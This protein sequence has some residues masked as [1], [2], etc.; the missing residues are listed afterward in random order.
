MPKTVFCRPTPTMTSVPWTETAAPMMPKMSAWLD[1]VGS[2][3]TNVMRSH[4]IAATSAAT[5]RSCV[6]TFES[7]MPAPT[8]F[9]TASPESAPTRFRPPAMR[10][11]C[12]GVSTRVATTVAIAFAASWKPLTNSK[13]T[14][15]RTTRISR[16]VALS[17][18][19]SSAVLHD[20]RFD[21]VR[22]VLAAVDRHLNERVDVLPLHDLDGVVGALEEVAD[23]LPPYL[24]ALVLERVDLD[25]ERLQVL[26]A[27]ELEEHRGDL[28]RRRHEDL[29]LPEGPRADALHLEEEDELRDVV[30][31]VGHVVDPGAE[32]DDVLPVQRRD[33]RLVDVLDDLGVQ[34][35]P[36]VLDRVDVPDL[37]LDV[38]EGGEQLLQ[39]L[40]RLDRV[41][42]VL[43]E[44]GEELALLR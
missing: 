16:T 2:A 41:L 5:T 29:R 22:D 30:A 8:V 36:V 33:E 21:D 34:L 17:T 37:V 32:S 4:T 10:M 25:P 26:Q 19:L 6:T 12:P 31:D 27:F 3:A 7:T 44:Q 35:V 18:A 13:R 15:R 39:R 43:R 14:P 28:A 1:E 23:G 38:V 40:G 11:A 24:V 20:D 9:A 42:R